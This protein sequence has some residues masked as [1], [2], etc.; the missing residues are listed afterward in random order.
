MK[1]EACGK[2]ERGWDE[3]RVGYACRDGKF[4]G[5]PHKSANIRDLNEVKKDLR[6][7][8]RYIAGKKEVR[9][10]V[11]GVK[12]DHCMRKI[13][14]GP[15]DIRTIIFSEGVRTIRQGAFHGVKSLR[16]ALLNEGLETLGTDE[17]LPD[18]KRYPGVFQES[19][20][21]RVKFPSTLKRIEYTTFMDCERLRVAHLPDK[22]EYIGGTSFSGTGLESVEFPA[23]VRTIC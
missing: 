17:Y 7:Q 2:I 6:N 18:G 19:G 22:L 1:D 21:K 14:G 3:E 4:I 15:D 10:T 8:I 16:A 23:S 5:V 20:L 13:F 9:T 11:S 12:Y